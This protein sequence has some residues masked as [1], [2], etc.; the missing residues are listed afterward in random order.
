[1]WGHPGTE[2]VQAPLHETNKA[3]QQKN[4][5]CS[6]RTRMGTEGKAKPVE[7]SH[8]HTLL[9]PASMYSHR[10]ENCSASRTNETV[11]A[12]WCVKSEIPVC[13][14][15]SCLP[16]CSTSVAVE[17]KPDEVSRNEFPQ[18]LVSPSQV[19]GFILAI[20]G[21]DRVTK[22]SLYFQVMTGTFMSCEV[23][24]ICVQ[25]VVCLYPYQRMDVC[26]KLTVSQSLLKKPH[27]EIT[28]ARTTC[29]TY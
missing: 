28:E 13:S 12:V 22:V 9:V 6:P 16:C 23:E 17:M 4:C 8:C 2:R 15:S 25:D 14:C 18:I 29:Q 24:S 27:S 5:T 19:K 10:A 20:V 21:M 1:M 26:E 3:V 7:Y 11:H